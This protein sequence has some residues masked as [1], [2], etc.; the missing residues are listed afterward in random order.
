[1]LS[2]R[3]LTVI[4]VQPLEKSM[5]TATAVR[6]RAPAFDTARS[7]AFIGKF[8][9]AMNNAAMILMTSVGHRTGLFDVL[10]ANS[11]CTSTELAKASGLAERYVREWLSVMTTSGVVDYDSG[12]R[13]FTLP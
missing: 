11:S 12:V 10:A 8:L 13:R 9:G 1:M 4:A 5:T 6:E 7:E 2:T 3:R